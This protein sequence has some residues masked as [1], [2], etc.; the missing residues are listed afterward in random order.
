MMK[1]RCVRSIR[2]RLLPAV[3]FILLMVFMLSV[4]HVHAETDSFT[5]GIEKIIPEM[6]IFYKSLYNDKEIR[7]IEDSYETVLK[8][9]ENRVNDECSYHFLTAKMHI[10]F[11]KHFGIKDDPNFDAARAKR[12]LKRGIAAAE[13][14]LEFQEHA[15]TYALL[16]EAAGSIF[17]LSPLRYLFSYG[18]ETQSASETAAELDAKHLSVL[19]LIGNTY[20]YAPNMYGGDAEKAYR[21]FLEALERYKQKSNSGMY[22]DPADLFTI[23]SSIGIALVKQ[24]DFKKGILWL[25]KAL[26]LYP[27]NTYARSYLTEAL[28][29]TES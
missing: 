13:K 1:N 25:K 28:E 10:L 22:A 3:P 20:L 8:A 7:Y 6:E 19:L 26:K 16:S 29:E 15:Q 24:E 12:S 14:S 4:M 5:A 11:G 21:T 2:S 9:I 23:Y 27:E 17:I 18:M